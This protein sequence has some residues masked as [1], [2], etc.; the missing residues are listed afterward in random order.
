MNN[1]DANNS[2]NNTPNSDEIMTDE[3]EALLKASGKREQPVPEV[4]DVIQ[5]STHQAWQ[6]AVRA[7]QKRMRQW[8]TSS[9]A[10]AVFFAAMLAVVLPN[11]SFDEPTA[12][13]HITQSYGD[14][15][16]N[17][18]QHDYSTIVY[19]GDKLSTAEDSIIG[20]KLPDNTLVTLDQNTRITL[21]NAAL[22]KVHSGR[23]YVDSPD[24]NTSILVSTPLGDIVDI[25]TQY[26]VTVT[27]NALDVA[28]RDG[29]TKITTAA[30]TVY[31]SVANGLG[32]VLHIVKNA[33][34]ERHKIATT[35]QHWQWTHKTMADF[36]L[37]NASVY[38]LLN[39][40]SR[41]TGKDI[42]Y[43][44][45]AT[46]RQAEETHLSG[47]NLSPNTISEQLPNILKTTTLTL[48][49]RRGAFIISEEST[50]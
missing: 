29:K 48:E 25:G 30:K 23:V 43:A 22:I 14:F 26:E 50:L 1:S 45:P 9:A 38:D 17:K 6:Q 34:I 12:V 10:A 40:A 13:A 36:N 33:P 28:M 18:K 11:I 2:R 46:Q 47:G 7:R 27:P 4:A 5:Q 39:W 41:V 20:I 42:V 31:A 32:E 44:S 37:H 49:E 3:L 19:Q 24:H 35:D 16:L 21:V 15:T 8:L